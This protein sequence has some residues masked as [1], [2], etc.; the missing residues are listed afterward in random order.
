MAFEEEKSNDYWEGVRDAL[1]LILDF[2]E[3]KTTNPQSER[4]LQEFIQEAR[5]KVAG[6]TK[7][8]PL[9]VAR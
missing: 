5:V 8:K 7:P 3:W 9:L 4:T 2:D 1:R 6:R